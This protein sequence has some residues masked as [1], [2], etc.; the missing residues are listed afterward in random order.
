M[1]AEE[2][3]NRLNE[4]KSYIESAVFQD[5]IMKPLYD[6]LDKLKASYECDTL[7]ELHRTKGEAIGLKKM[8]DILKQVEV[9]MKNAQTEYEEEKS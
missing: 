5:C 7:K 8:I 3:L 4:L 2:N 9:D 6:E 1:T